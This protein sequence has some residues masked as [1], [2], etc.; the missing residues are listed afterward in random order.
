MIFEH[1]FKCEY[2][3]ATIS[4][5]PMRSEPS[6]R[7][8]MCSEVLFGEEIEIIEKF[9]KW[10]KI[11]SKKDKYEGFIS[12]NM[13]PREENDF[14]EPRIISSSI[15]IATSQGETPIILPA[16]SLVPKEGIFINNKHYK[17]KDEDCL[18]RNF[19]EIEK[20]AL[21]FLNAPYLWGGKTI[22]GIDCS[23]FV[24][25]VFFICGKQLPR[26][27][28]QQVALGTT[29]DFLTETKTGDLAF[30]ENENGKIVHVGILLNNHQIIHASGQVKIS[31]IDNYGILA[32]SQNGYSHKL[33]IIKRID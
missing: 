15:A 10:S 3:R 9:D 23:G 21:Q 8:E 30:F 20:V 26:D 1:Y 6:E 25:T 16:G 28:S 7:S 5:I 13:L 31:Q 24:Q 4:V 27:A 18:E 2:M 11:R 17:I 19:C 14:R 22:F 12:N 32:D 33:R 29:V